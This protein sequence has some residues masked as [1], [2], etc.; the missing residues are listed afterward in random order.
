MSE[1][2]ILVGDKVLVEPDPE[3]AKSEGGL[4]LPQGIK[5]KEKVWSGR[6]VKVGPGYPVLDPSSLEEEPWLTQKSRAKYFPLQAQPQD[7]CI[8]L[9]EQAVEIR[10]NKKKY[11]ILA[12]SA[13]LLLI[14]E[15]HS[16]KEDL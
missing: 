1:E 13:I 5:E 6:V 14:R 10:F 4:Y 12:Q 7:K 8:F 16:A 9:K 15:S 3:E 2:L 11:L